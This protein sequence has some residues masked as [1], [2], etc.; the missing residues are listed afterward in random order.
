MTLRRGEGNKFQHRFD[1]TWLHFGC[2]SDLTEPDPLIFY[3]P[4][5]NS[6]CSQVSK[7]SSSVRFQFFP[8]TLTWPQITTFLPL[9]LKLVVL[10]PLSTL[11]TFSLMFCISPPTYHLW[12]WHKACSL[13][14]WSL[15]NH[16]I[17]LAVV[18]R[19]FAECAQALWYVAFHAFFIHL[20]IFV[21]ATL[22]NIPKWALCG[23]Y[24][25]SGSGEM[26]LMG[27]SWSDM[28]RNGKGAVGWDRHVSP[29]MVEL[30][31]L[32]FT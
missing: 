17:H 31:V 14:F 26:R 13:N 3:K 7:Q 2:I 8:V 25:N 15:H 11:S 30:R 24:K 5:P 12:S 16:Q 27:W 19:T 4:W 18:V 20:M 1:W 21:R 32:K 22:S 10:P 29:N 9:A 23:L 28:I 6:D